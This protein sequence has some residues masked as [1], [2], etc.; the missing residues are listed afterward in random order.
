MNFYVQDFFPPSTSNLVLK[1]DSL[2][3]LSKKPVSLLLFRAVSPSLA[4]SMTSLKKQHSTF[5][6][7]IPEA[8]KV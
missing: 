2:Q 5:N 6:K 7:T 8:I 3:F 4:I 1:N